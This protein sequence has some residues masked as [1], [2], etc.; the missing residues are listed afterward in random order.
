MNNPGDLP[1]SDRI[2]KRRA[3]GRFALG[4]AQMLFA[5]ATIV[6]LLLT[7]ITLLTV[8]LA[9]ITTTL[10]L[11]SVALFRDFLGFGRK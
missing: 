4:H 7:G 9:V 3:W 11:I 6:A 1:P 2:S 5:V 10:V 8:L